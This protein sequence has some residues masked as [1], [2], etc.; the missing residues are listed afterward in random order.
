[1]SDHEPDISK[2]VPAPPGGVQSDLTPEQW[3]RIKEL[4]AAAR[5]RGGVE[6]NAFL[7]EACGTDRSLVA[8][9]ESLLAAAESED[10]TA[11]EVD[12]PSGS[13]A[14]QSA[15]SADD[16]L[17]GRRLGAYRIEQGIGQGGMA[18]VYLASRADEEYQKQVAIKLLRP[19]LDS[20]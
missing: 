8:E 2:H 6:R 12:A 16:P 20:G 13:S 19:E 5:D 7:K 9:V 3:Q 11:K 10:L 15:A 18:T 4:F 14:R 1:M 17:I